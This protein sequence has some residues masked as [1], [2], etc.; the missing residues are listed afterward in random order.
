MLLDFKKPP[1]IILESIVSYTGKYKGFLGSHYHAGVLCHVVG[2]VNKLDGS[3]TVRHYNEKI[4][5]HV[6]QE[7]AKH[8]ATT[9]WKSFQAILVNKP[10]HPEEDEQ[11]KQWFDRYSTRMREGERRQLSKRSDA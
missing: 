4:S 8:A 9:Y 7:A 2:A 6:N 5:P 3:I 1:Y 10:Q 11:L